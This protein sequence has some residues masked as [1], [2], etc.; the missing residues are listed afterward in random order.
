MAHGT[1]E[2]ANA[3]MRH[4]VTE[5]ESSEVHPKP[6]GKDVEIKEYQDQELSAKDKI[7]HVNITSSED[8]KQEDAVDA[9]LEVPRRWTPENIDASGQENSSGKQMSDRTLPEKGGGQDSIE[10]AGKPAGPSATLDL[11]AISGEL[12]WGV[13]VSIPHKD[14]K[15]AE[16]RGSVLGNV[17]FHQGLGPHTHQGG[18]QC[19][20]HHIHE[21]PWEGQESPR[22]V[23]QGPGLTSLRSMESTKTQALSRYLQNGTYHWYDRYCAWAQ[24]LLYGSRAQMTR[25]DVIS[26][27]LKNPGTNKNQ[28]GLSPSIITR[29]VVAEDSTE[30][31]SGRGCDPRQIW[32]F[33]KGPLCSRNN[34]ILRGIS[35]GE[36]WRLYPR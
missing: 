34:A 7:N 22:Y 33:C 14:W 12:L 16:E 20:E 2:K 29:A 23:G 28:E 9:L 36:Y 26:G 4:P 32:R 3:P 6:V 19:M 17:D 11:D 15:P 8:A 30:K 1:A 31:P 24:D 13:V 27:G 18:A 5:I 25:D 21:W 10:G 35:T